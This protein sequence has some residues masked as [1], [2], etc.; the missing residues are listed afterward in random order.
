MS[1]FFLQ[2][3]DERS[4]NNHKNYVNVNLEMK[5]ISL[6]FIFTSF[7]V[8]TYSYHIFICGERERESFSQRERERE[9]SL[10]VSL[11]L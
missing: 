9:Q 11:Q 7:F 4:D 6:R 8:V 1:Q 5:Q 3:E 10:E 2:E